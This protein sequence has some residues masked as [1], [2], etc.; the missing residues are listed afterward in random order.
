MTRVN[1]R[2]YSFRR[3]ETD[4]GRGLGRRIAVA[5]IEKFLD[6]SRYRGFKSSAEST[7]STK[8]SLLDCL[9]RFFSLVFHALDLL[10]QLVHL[11]IGYF[12]VV[13]RLPHRTD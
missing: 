6:R 13:Q 8:N 3:T 12:I 9:L 1:H 7:G 5:N 10:P 11:R 2:R 4:R